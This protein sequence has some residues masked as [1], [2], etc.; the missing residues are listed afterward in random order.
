MPT[1]RLGRSVAGVSAI[2]TSGI[3][4]PIALKSAIRPAPSAMPAPVPM[5]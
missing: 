5:N 2:G 1:I 4:R 3:V